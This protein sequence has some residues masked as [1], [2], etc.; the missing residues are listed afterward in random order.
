MLPANALALWAEACSQTGIDWY[1]YK[2]TLLCAEG[3]H[4]LPEALSCAEI[5]VFAKDLP[6]LVQQ[7]FPRLPQHWTLSKWNF[8]GRARTLAFE[9]NQRPVLEISVLCCVEDE[10]QMDTLANTLNKTTFAPPRIIGPLRQPLERI[11][12]RLLHS[13]AEQCFHS[14]VALAGASDGEHSFC[15]DCFTNKTPM[16]FSKALFAETQ[17]LPCVGLYE[18]EGDAEKETF[19]QETHYPVFSGYRT[20]LEAVYGD[21]EAG[22]FDEIGCGLSVEEKEDLKAHQKHCLEA[23]AFVQEISREFGLRYYLLAGSVLGAVRHGGFIPWD[24]DIDIGIR[25]EDLAEFEK[26]VKEQLPLRLPEHF[27]LKQSAAYDP[28]PRM[29]SK[30]CYDGRCCIDLWPLVPTYNTGFRAKFT[31]YFAKLITKVHYQKIGHVFV[32]YWALARFTG[33]LLTDGMVMWLAR[34]N[35]RKYMRRKTPAYINIYSIY[36][37]EKETIQRSWLDTEATA[38]FAGLEVPV[39]GQT[40]AYLTHMYGDYMAFPPP[41]KRA[42][43]H[44]ARF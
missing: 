31:W 24:D 21:Y 26:V 27:T 1:L 37:R 20:Y 17:M 30:I 12:H 28:Y 38:D 34:R 18:T 5:V 14:R 39:V 32:R 3:Y 8:I 40:E 10:A 29:F 15:C 2:N 16:L 41:W 11:Q 36:R 9:E 22:L 6:Q 43:R 23:L 4:H 7:V 13:K 25:I 35:E 44:V 42:S 19:E 33:L